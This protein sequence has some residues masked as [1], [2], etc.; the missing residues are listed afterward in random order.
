M[1]PPCQLTG[2]TY[3]I[4]IGGS[5]NSNKDTSLQFGFDTMSIVP[6]NRASRWFKQGRLGVTG[7]TKLDLVSDVKQITVTCDTSLTKIVGISFIKK[8]GTVNTFPKTA[9]QGQVITLYD[10]SFGKMN[11]AYSGT[12]ANNM[13]WSFQFP[14]SRYTDACKAPTTRANGY[15][16]TK[17]TINGFT[18]S[19]D[20]TGKIV[21]SFVISG[22]GC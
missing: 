16:T 7:A 20:S 2:E 17:C 21:T 22:T 14:G 3:P 18:G 6:V 11:T 8:D 19:L 13:P 9:V 4:S 5:S 15:D 1:N 10:S 12:S